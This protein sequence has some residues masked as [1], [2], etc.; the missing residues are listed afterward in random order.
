MFKIL[1]AAIIQIKADKNLNILFLG[2]NKVIV[3]TTN[4]AETKFP[5]ILIITT[6]KLKAKAVT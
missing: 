3:F 1:R 5:K 6:G 2:K 4:Q